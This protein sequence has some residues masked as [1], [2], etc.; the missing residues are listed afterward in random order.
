M[1]LVLTA[2]RVLITSDKFCYVC[3]QFIIKSQTRSPTKTVKKAYVLYFGYQ[4]G[5]Q[6]KSSA[7]HVCCVTCCVSLME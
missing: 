7:P 5:D 2:D 6:D 4:V 1:W 3:G